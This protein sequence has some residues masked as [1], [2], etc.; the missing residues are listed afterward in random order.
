MF[1]LCRSP[2]DAESND[3]DFVH[4]HSPS[5]TLEPIPSIPKIAIL[6]EIVGAIDLRAAMAGKNQR[7][8]T[9]SGLPDAHCVV[10]LVGTKGG[11]GKVVHTTDVIRQCENPIFTCKTRSLC[12]LQ[13]PNILHH[14]VTKN[15]NK[16]PDSA[17][18]SHSS[19]LDKSSNKEIVMA[20][21]E[22]G[23]P[24]AFLVV[25]VCHG[26]KCLGKVEISLEHILNCQGEREEFTIVSESNHEVE[27]AGQEDPTIAVARESIIQREMPTMLAKSQENQKAK[28]ALRFRPAKEKDIQ[29]L[30]KIEKRRNESLLKSSAQ[31]VKASLT[32]SASTLAIDPS[33]QAEPSHEVEATDLSFKHV[34]KKSLLAAHKKTDVATGETFHRLQPPKPSASDEIAVDFMTKTQ[35]QNE[36][37]KPSQKWVETGHGELGTLFLEVIGCDNLPDLD[38]GTSDLTDPFVACV[39]E[40][41]MVVS[42]AHPIFSWAMFWILSSPHVERRWISLA[43]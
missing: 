6:A 8:S 41:N 43:H 17:E 5:K 20:E 18:A 37:Y 13:I 25:E 39:F 38:M 26:K 9:V 30:A 1:R 34:T 24:E 11:E 32:K 33:S 21:K 35:I 10:R 3:D 7:K 23:Q 22:V 28:L 12:V 4:L 27:V 42:K 15:D 31:S 40:D 36:A 16:N 19:S 2:H 29:L 14:D